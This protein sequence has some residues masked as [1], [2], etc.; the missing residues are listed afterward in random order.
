MKAVWFGKLT[1]SVYVQEFEAGRSFGIP[2]MVF[3]EYD[4]ASD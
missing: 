3:V 1:D 2:H 4:A